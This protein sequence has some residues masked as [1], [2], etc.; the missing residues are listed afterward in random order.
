MIIRPFTLADT[1]QTIALW[2][3]CELIASHNDPLKDIERKMKVDPDLFLVGDKDGQ[4]IA[5]VMAGYEGHRGW[6]YYLAVSPQHQGQGIGKV[7]VLEA[8]KLLLA[9]GAPK[10]DLMVR[11]TND[12]VIG[13]YQSLGYAAEAVTVM[14]KRL[15]NDR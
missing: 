7:I 11:S 4:V 12:K 13:F 9:K 2:R 15:I 8:E 5:T 6:I 14:G 3:A 1:E 10:I